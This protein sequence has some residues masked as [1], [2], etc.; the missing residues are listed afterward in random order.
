MYNKQVVIRKLQFLH[1][2]RFFIAYGY[3]V[4]ACYFEILILKNSGPQFFNLSIQNDTL[5]AIDC[6]SEILCK[7]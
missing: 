3:Y 2:G 5:I 4:E 6:V 1:P 7:S